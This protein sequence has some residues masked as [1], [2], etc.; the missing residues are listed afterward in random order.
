MS[1]D[2]TMTIVGNLTADVESGYSKTGTAWARFT[3]ASTPRR[4]DTNTGGW[5]DGEALFLRCTVWRDL[6]EHAVQSLTKGQRVI[7]T[8]KLRQ[9]SWETPEGD[10][11]TAIGLDV[12]EIGPSLRWATA[13]VTRMTRTNAGAEPPQDPWAGPTVPAAR[14]PSTDALAVPSGPHAPAPPF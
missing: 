3:I 10:K 8:G 9:S 6:A 11:R 4:Y 14:T 2:T 12:D 7:A 5:V 13:K 1:Q